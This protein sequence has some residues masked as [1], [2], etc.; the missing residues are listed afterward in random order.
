MGGASKMWTGRLREFRLGRVALKSPIVEMAEAT[1]GAFA[2]PDIAGIIGGELLRRFRVT[3]DC[4]RKRMIL[5]PTER[6]GEPFDEEMSGIR[7]LSG[8]PDYR[9][10][11][12][13]AVMP[14]SPAMEAGVHGGDLLVSVND[15][16]ASAFG[17]WDLR[18]YLRVPDRDVRLKLRRGGQQ[19]EVRLK[20]RRMV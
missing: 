7:W 20:L 6:V 3:F 15:E 19:V 16:P 13:R 4:P 9:E 5:E 18:Q 8:G 12:A 17:K 11:R 2:R 1:G 10:F 14:E